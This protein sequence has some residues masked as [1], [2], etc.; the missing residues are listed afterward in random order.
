MP[1]GGLIAGDHRFAGFQLEPL[2]NFDGAPIGTANDDAALYLFLSKP[3][4]IL[5][6]S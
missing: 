1:H 5:S 3:N 2:N 6:L 4:T